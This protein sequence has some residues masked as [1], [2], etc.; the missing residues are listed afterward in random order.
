MWGFGKNKENLFIH[1]IKIIFNIFA[2]IFEL[3]KSS[4]DHK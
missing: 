4:E 1:Y 2:D 3:R